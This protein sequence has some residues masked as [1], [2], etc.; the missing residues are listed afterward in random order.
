MHMVI[1]IR[2]IFYQVLLH[3]LTVVIVLVFK[4]DV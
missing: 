2:D 3:R 4:H 1:T